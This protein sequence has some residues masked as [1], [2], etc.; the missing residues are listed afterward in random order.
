MK[1]VGYDHLSALIVL[2]ENLL[3][4]D[5]RQGNFLIIELW[6]PGRVFVGPATRI[7]TMG[8]GTINI[9]HEQSKINH[10]DNPQSIG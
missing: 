8:A 2:F 5:D 4:H 10:V 7:Q 9:H 6:R 1:F 3:T